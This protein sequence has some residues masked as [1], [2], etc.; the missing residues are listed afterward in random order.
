MKQLQ[1]KIVQLENKTGNAVSNA[2]DSAK[3]AVGATGAVAGAPRMVL[4]GP[5]GAGTSYSP[6][7][8]S[9]YSSST[10]FAAHNI[11]HTA[12]KRPSPDG[13]RRHC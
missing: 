13:E 6:L 1:N 2:I 5:P 9:T 7:L 3:S 10:S 12:G 11:V 4:I 8:S